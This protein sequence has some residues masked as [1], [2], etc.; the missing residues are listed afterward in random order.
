MCAVRIHGLS[1]VQFTPGQA[2]DS[3]YNLREVRCQIKRLCVLSGFHGAWRDPPLLAFLHWTVCHCQLCP[4]C[5]SQIATLRHNCAY[6]EYHTNFWDS[7]QD[8]KYLQ[9][10]FV[11]PCSFHQSWS[12][13]P[14]DGKLG[15]EHRGHLPLFFLQALF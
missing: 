15:E 8:L 1:A 6:S 10:T 7:V 5:C 9:N 11:A 12:L 4:G 13:L 3:F 2:W 14:S